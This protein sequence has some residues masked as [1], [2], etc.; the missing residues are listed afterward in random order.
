M[1]MLSEKTDVRMTAAEIA[2]ALCAK[3]QNCEDTS[4]SV[5]GFSTDTRTIAQGSA[6]LR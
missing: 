1:A 5:A 3:L 4:F 6:S 2:E